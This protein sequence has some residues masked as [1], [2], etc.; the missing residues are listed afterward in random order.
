MSACAKL[1]LGGGESDRRGGSGNTIGV[2]RYQ[3]VAVECRKA[4]VGGLR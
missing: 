3:Y 1:F 4:I 2:G